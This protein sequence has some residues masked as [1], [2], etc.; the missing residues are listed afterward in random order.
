MIEQ[1][2]LNQTWAMLS[3]LII[4]HPSFNLAYQA[5]RN[6]YLFNQKTGLS[7]EIPHRTF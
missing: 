2:E 1:T 3:R 6:A 5:L 7:T 4:K